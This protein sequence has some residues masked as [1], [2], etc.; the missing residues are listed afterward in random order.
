MREKAKE[1]GADKREDLPFIRNTVAQKSIAK[2]VLDD[3]DELL[4]R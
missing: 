4:F 1:D 2:V 3:P